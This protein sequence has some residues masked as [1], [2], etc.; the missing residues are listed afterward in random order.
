[1][2]VL[3]LTLVLAVVI[4][5]SM[6]NY[7]NCTVKLSPELGAGAKSV[8]GLASLASS[9]GV[10]LGGAAAG[11]DAIGP[12]LYPDLMNSV[13]FKTSLFNVPVTIEG[14]KEADEQDRCMTCKCPNPGSGLIWLR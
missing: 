12:T 14:D 7:Y 10:D 8:G 3:P 9:F 1:M 11:I 13:D 5:L 2:K 4:S 6:P